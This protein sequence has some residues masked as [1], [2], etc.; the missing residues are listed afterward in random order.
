M[1][2]SINIDEAQFHAMIKLL[3]NKASDLFLSPACRQFLARDQFEKRGRPV[4]EFQDVT[5]GT[6]PGTVAHNRLQID[7]GTFASATRT[8][9]LINPLTSIQDVFLGAGSMKVLSIGPRT[10]MELLHLAGIGFQPKNISALDLISTSPWIDLGDMHALPYPDRAFHV[11]I[12]GWVLGYSKAPQKAVDEM[13]R[14]TRDG[15]LVAIG[16]THNPK[17]AEIEYKDEQARI[18]G[19]IFH[20]VAELKDLI[21]ARMGQVFFQHEPETGEINVV[22]LICRIRH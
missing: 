20:R 22:M 19:R 8:A 6:M 2:N 17:A 9:R 11:V 10:E 18:Q 1:A 13:L 12:S 7:D 4:R 15:G 14:V 21:G 5:T 3:A 16:C